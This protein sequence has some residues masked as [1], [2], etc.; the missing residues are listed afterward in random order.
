MNKLSPSSHNEYISDQEELNEYFSFVKQNIDSGK[1]FKD[2]IDWYYF[3][4]VNQICE[5]AYLIIAIVI[6]LSI[7]YVVKTMS[8]SLF[9]L[10]VPQ[11][12]FISAKSTK[13]A[14][15]KIVK[16]KPRKGEANFDPRVENFDDSIIK[17]LLKN[18]VINREK[19][20]FKDGDI[21]Q[22]NKKF[23][24]IK[25]TS[26]LREY[27]NF[28]KYMSK[29]NPN[30]PI[31]LFSKNATREITINEIKFYR[32][33]PKNFAEKIIF[34]IANSIPYEADV[35]FSSNTKTYN[36]IGLPIYNT[37]KFMA[38]IKYD[39]QPFFKTNTQANINFSVSQYVLYKVK[40]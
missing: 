9:P 18:Y 28:Q 2:A 29:D 7:S 10:V 26:T 38:K 24:R 27:K 23:N 5:R 20:D 35:F 6:L 19:F 32:K 40:N 15:P 36:D 1:Y 3:R 17:Y 22:V 37:E 30:S 11:P 34:Y 16:L 21:E 14:V 39:Y 12:I 25:N 8:D 31:K 33:T 13:D 4:Y